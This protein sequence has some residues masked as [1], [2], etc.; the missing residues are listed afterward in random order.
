M[1]DNRSGATK[2]RRRKW[3]WIGHTHS[4]EACKQHH[5]AGSDIE[6][7]GEEIEGKI[8]EHMAQRRLG[9]NTER[10]SLLEGPGEGSLQL[11]ALADCRRWPVLPRG[12]LLL[13]LVGCLA[14]QQHVS[15]SQARICSDNCTCCHT[16]AEIADQT[17]YLIQPQNTDTGRTSPNADPLTPCR[18]ATGG[19]LFKPVE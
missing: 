13:L 17:F 11:G 2:I 16:E 15:V 12:L 10:R 4:Q 5:Q 7:T 8:Q 18:I 9:R 1:D 14:S 6:S 19:L 3:V